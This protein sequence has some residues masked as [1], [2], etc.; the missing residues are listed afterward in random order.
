M[1]VSLTNETGEISGFLRD[2]SEGGLKIQ[3]ISAERRVEKGD[4]DCTF[5]LPNLGKMQTRV[6]VLGVGDSQEKLGE[7]L[8]RMRFQNLDPLSKEKIKQFIANS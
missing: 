6:E 5:V 7:T 3:K 2:I 1:L 4:Y 8:V